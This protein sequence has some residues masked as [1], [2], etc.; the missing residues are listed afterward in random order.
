MPANVDLANPRAASLRRGTFTGSPTTP[1]G[2]S[3]R[4]TMTATWMVLLYGD[5]GFWSTAT[6]ETK[7]QIRSE[8]RAY[9]A[10]CSEQGHKILGGSEL[11]F[12]SKAYSTHRS[13]DGTIDIMRGAY[14]ET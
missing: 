12:S 3:E 8:H 10:A 9:A 13:D 6:P 14:N 5:E 7:D 11:G 1:G 4:E 2:E